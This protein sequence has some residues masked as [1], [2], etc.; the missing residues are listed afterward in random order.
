M[1]D[2]KGCAKIRQ[3]ISGPFGDPRMDKTSVLQSF[4]EPIL[5]FFERA[6]KLVG[7]S[8][9]EPFYTGTVQHP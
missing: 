4:A 2:E 9:C 8:S 3:K 5:G 7:G 1:L 6:R